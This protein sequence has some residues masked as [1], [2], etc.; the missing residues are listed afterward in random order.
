MLEEM[1]GKNT[2]RLQSSNVEKKRKK[3]KVRYT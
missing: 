3:K 1:V 2:D